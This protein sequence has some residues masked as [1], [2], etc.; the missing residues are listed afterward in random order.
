MLLRYLGAPEDRQRAAFA[1]M[2]EY[3]GKFV[4]S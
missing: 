4:I 1:K 2:D 3:F